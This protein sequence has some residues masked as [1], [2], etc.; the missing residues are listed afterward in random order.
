MFQNQS[1]PGPWNQMPQSIASPVTINHIGAPS[2][3][4]A[5]HVGDG[6]TFSTNYVDRSLPTSANYVG[7]TIF[8]TPNHSHVISLASIHHTGDDSLSPTSHIKKPRCL[9]HKVKF[10]CR[11]CE[12]SHLTHLCLATTGIL[13]AWGSPKSP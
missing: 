1:F 11:T 2:P 6:S 13:E 9:K 4:S 5:S 3:T 7:G 8:F 12:G 10:F